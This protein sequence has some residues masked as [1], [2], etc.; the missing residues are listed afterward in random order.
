M[1]TNA[2]QLPEE[3]KKELANILEES[4]PEEAEKMVTN[5]EHTL[6]R[7]YEEGLLAGEARGMEQTARRMLTKNMSEDL[8]A[9]V[10]GLSLDQIKKLKSEIAGDTH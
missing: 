8:I 5:M 6:G 7:M 1:V 2:S 4:R 3:A 10:T 9:E